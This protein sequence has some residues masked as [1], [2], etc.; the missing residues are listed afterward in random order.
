MYKAF[1]GVFAGNE[2]EYRV[3]VKKNNLKPETTLNIRSPWD[4]RFARLKG[5]FCTGQYWE[6]SFFQNPDRDTMLRAHTDERYVKKPDLEV[7]VPRKVLFNLAGMRLSGLGKIQS[8]TDGG[9]FYAMYHAISSSYR[10]DLHNHF[11]QILV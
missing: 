7:C 1:I 2:H 11:L 4:L 3:F 8:L 9:L 10:N 6:N 5:T